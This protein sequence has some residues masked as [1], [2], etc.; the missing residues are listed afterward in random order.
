MGCYGSGRGFLILEMVVPTGQFLLD[1]GSL[2]V[3]PVLFPRA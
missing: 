1:L 3:D 2:A